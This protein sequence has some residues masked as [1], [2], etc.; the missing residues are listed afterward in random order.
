LPLRRSLLKSKPLKQLL[1][2]NLLK[3]LL[4][5]SKLRRKPLKKL[6]INWL[7]RPKRRLKQLLLKRKLKMIIIMLL[8]SNRE[9]KNHSKES[10]T[11]S[12]QT[13]WRML[14]QEN[15]MM[16]LI[17]LLWLKDDSIT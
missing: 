6:L 2:R 15:M 4:S 14:N 11:K 16:P 13:N 3:R 9:N 12:S 8:P 1:I 17:K 10:K 5:K 7:K